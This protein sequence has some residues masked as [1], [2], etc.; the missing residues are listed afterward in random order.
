MGITLR[1]LPDIRNSK[2]TEVLEILITYG[3]DLDI[4]DPVANCSKI[5]GCKILKE[6]TV[7]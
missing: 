6:L 3:L 1:K 5:S 4:Y 2:S 7:I